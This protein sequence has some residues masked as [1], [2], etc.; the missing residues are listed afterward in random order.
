ME[1]SRGAVSAFSRTR[2]AKS[3]FDDNPSVN[4]NLGETLVCS[5]RTFA[6]IR[7]ITEIRIRILQ[8]A[9]FSRLWL[10]YKRQVSISSEN[11]LLRPERRDAICEE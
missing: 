6:N 7:D 11:H 5:M 2:D 3:T 4:W 8:R 9:R 1:V 10:S